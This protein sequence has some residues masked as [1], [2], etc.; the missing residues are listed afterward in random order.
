MASADDIEDAQRAKLLRYWENR[1]QARVLATDRTEAAVNR[2]VLQAYASTTNAIEDELR[3]F[4][5][6]FAS[7]S[8]LSLDDARATLSVRERADFRA[9]LA[10]KQDA[11]RALPGPLG[12]QL[13]GYLDDLGE[14]SK[15]RKV[16][17]QQRLLLDIEHELTDMSAAVGRRL[18]TGMFEAFEQRFEGNAK[19]LA[20]VPAFR[21]ELGAPA[22]SLLEQAASEKWLGQ[23]F[24]ER[25]W[26]DKEK[27]VSELRRILSQAAVSH[28][29]IEALTKKM[30]RAMGSSLD[31]ARRL[32]RT[33]LNYVANQASLEG[34][35]KS[36]V[37]HYKFLAAIDSRTS[38]ICR[39]TSGQVFAV[40]EAKVGVNFPPLH[41]NCRSTTVAHFTDEDLAQRYDFSH[42]QLSAEE[43]AEL[44]VSREE[45][46]QQKTGGEAIELTQRE[47]TR[48]EDAVNKAPLEGESLRV[49]SRLERLGED[50]RFEL[51]LEQ[52]L[53]NGKVPHT[54]ATIEVRNERLKE[55][56]SRI[57]GEE[58]LVAEL[59]ERAGVVR[60][61]AD[62]KASSP[63]PKAVPKLVDELTPVP[64]K[65]SKKKKRSAVEKMVDAA[66]ALVEKLKVVF[67]GLAQGL[68]R[69]A[70]RV[71]GQVTISRR[72]GDP[73]TI[74]EGGGRLSKRQE[75]LLAQL[76]APGDLIVVRKRD[77]S[78][79]DISALTAHEHVEF[80]LFTRNGE[81][82]V[83]RGARST[84]PITPGDASR[85]AR[86]GWRWSGHSHPGITDA[87]ISAS[88]S[89][90]V[91]L[92]AFGQ[93]RSVVVNSV[94][95]YREFTWNLSS[96]IPR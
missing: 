36:G 26:E 51:E 69:L 68:W 89:D 7:Q 10:A 63:R 66:R 37:K 39:E 13:Q 88:D 27:L 90:K 3:A 77:V 55:F 84:V 60:P 9:D 86:Q 38:E 35:R 83:V 64:F 81:R 75:T 20:K 17:R 62:A 96:W 67:N 5:E 70:R 33:E 95:R 72:R 12:E 4:Y 52:T 71:F 82:M 49:N 53:D 61:K 19:D 31:N 58:E 18:E 93:E 80:A 6:R 56:R 92:R 54:P 45:V 8:G 91:V 46:S 43:L 11:I 94:G 48:A 34:Y 21:A 16:T 57:K 14:A 41:P 73:E 59:E 24:S 1:A 44:G 30:A 65:A 23:N 32:V 25:V 15:L 22:P 85:L 76:H 2:E 40:D 47:A 78:L 74:Y 50:L 79:R 42:I 28:S 87:G 29:G